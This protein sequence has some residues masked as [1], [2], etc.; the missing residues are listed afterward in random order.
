VFETRTP[1]FG[2][3][4]LARAW[5]IPCLRSG[6]EGE[7]FEWRVVAT[8]TTWRKSQGCFGNLRN[9]SLAS[10]LDANVVR[11]TT[12]RET[13]IINVSLASKLNAKL[14]RVTTG[15]ETFIIIVLIASK[16]YAKMTRVPTGRHTFV[17]FITLLCYVSKTK[18]D[19]KI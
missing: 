14:V 13:F 6:E 1:S 19:V 10:K 15:R 2:I 5:W 11:V 17:F 9:V 18:E 16:P 3:R 4:A 8:I 12:G 7:V